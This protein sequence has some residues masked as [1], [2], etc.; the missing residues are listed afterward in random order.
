[1]SGYVDSQR[2]MTYCQVNMTE[3]PSR[4]HS[5]RGE[6]IGSIIAAIAVIFGF[7][8]LFGLV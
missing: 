2:I 1:M 4:I 3:V 8:A 7:A 5:K 6:T